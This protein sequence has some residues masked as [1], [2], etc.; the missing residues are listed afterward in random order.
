GVALGHVEVT[1]GVRDEEGSLDDRFEERRGERIETRGNGRFGAVGLARVGRR[2][3]TEDALLLLAG[4]R[5]LALRDAGR[6]PGKE[7]HAVGHGRTL[8]K[9]RRGVSPYRAQRASLTG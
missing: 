4:L 8:A 5:G 1:V 9:T 3:L 2:R 7:A 6:H